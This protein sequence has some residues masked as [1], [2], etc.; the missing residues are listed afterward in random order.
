MATRKWK[1]HG[2]VEPY[3]YQLSPELLRTG[4]ESVW[5][6]FYR[7][8]VSKFGRSSYRYQIR[9]KLDGEFYQTREN[10]ALST[11]KENAYF[12]YGK[13]VQNEGGKLLGTD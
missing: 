8:G 2:E 5:L 4:I 6:V 9:Y 1:R 11:A 13:I 12:H 3:E 7:Y 10:Y